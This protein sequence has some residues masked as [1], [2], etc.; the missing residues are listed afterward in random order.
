[1]Q[2]LTTYCDP[3]THLPFL[4]MELCDKNLCGFLEQLAVPLLYHTE[5][6]ISHDNALAFV[7]L[8]SNG[9]VHRDL[10]G[11]NVL[12]IAE[13]H[14]KVTDFDMSKLTSVNP[15]MT[16]L[17]LCQG[18]V[19]YMSPEA[20]EEKP[21]F[22]EKLDIFS[23]RVLLVQIMTRQFPDPGP[24]FQV[25]NIPDDPHI[26]KGTV[27]VPTPETQRRSA[28]LQ[29]ISRTHTL[30]AIAINCLKG[31]KKERPSAHQLSNTLSEL[32][33]APQYAESMQQPPNGEGNMQELASLRRQVQDLQQQN[34]EQRQENEQ[35]RQ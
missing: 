30:K 7:Y 10:T 18:N 2:Y 29:L 23:F 26:P 9:L 35:L 17:T 15:R 33:G 24:R 27:R 32:K 14:A 21:S 3:E 13:P 31:K 28:H 1:M 8:H 19:Q 25:L 22:T 34:Q 5:L 11:N 6:N 12:M 4:L 16:P 20:L